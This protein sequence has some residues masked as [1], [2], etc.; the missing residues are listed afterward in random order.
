MRALM[1]VGISTL[2]LAG[3]DGTGAGQA[4][5]A[6]AMLPTPKPGLWR[7]SLS[8]DGRSLDLI[9][10]V[11]ACLD[12]DA[13][14]RLSALGGRADKAMCQEQA[15]THDPDG[16][17]RFS[18]TCDMGPGGHVVTRGLLT[19]DLASRYRVHSQTDTSGASLA[20]MN[21]RHVI[22]IEADYLGPCPVDMIPG[23]VVIANGLK[24]NMNHLRAAARSL[25]GGG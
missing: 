23:D 7:E 4:P 2:A 13:R 17:Y 24:V 9:G 20:S 12:A 14:S 11:R 16:G 18:S 10:D 22:D 6:E 3:C 19:G 25:T 15:V 8:R 5:K 1:V 21:G